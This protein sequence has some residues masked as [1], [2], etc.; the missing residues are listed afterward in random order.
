MNDEHEGDGPERP[1]PG[2]L[3]ET[4]PEFIRYARQRQKKA[5]APA[6]A[7]APPPSPPRQEI[8]VRQAVLASGTVILLFALVF[9]WRSGTGT[10]KK[11]VPPWVVKAKAKA[12]AWID[13]PRPQTMGA[14]P[15][16]WAGLRLGMPLGAVDETRRSPYKEQDRWA[17]WIYHPDS[18]RPDA[19]FGL[20]FHK[21]QL[22]KIAVRFGEDSSITA[23]QF[24]SAGRVAYGAPRGYEYLT[25]GQNHAVTIFQTDSR[26]LKLDSVKAPEDVYLCEVVLV[27]LDVGAARELARA[28]GKE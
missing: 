5:K 21:G 10:R 13:L 15:D 7:P 23:G 8:T 26:A 17:D 22:Y 4:F 19:F 1:A 11:E 18:S 14:V 20:S 12:S 25:P 2:K 16:A 28:R 6:T 24:L 27:D 3:S 9:L